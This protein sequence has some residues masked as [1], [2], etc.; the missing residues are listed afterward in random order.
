M[1]LWRVFGHA[2]VLPGRG[3]GP[4]S[5]EDLLSMFMPITPGGELFLIAVAVLSL[6]QIAPIKINPWDVI[7]GWAGKKINAG[8]KEQL[9][10]VQKQSDIQKAEFREFWIDY[11]RESI[12]R[13]SR[14]CSQEVPHSRE[15]WNHILDI[16]KRYEHFCRKYDIVNGVVEENSDY[17]RSLHRQLLQEHKI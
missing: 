12:L 10:T 8:V 7:L 2:F 13:F 14:E 16:I 6:V 9:D 4:L 3:K 17:L 11:Q 1:Y 15:E 5:L